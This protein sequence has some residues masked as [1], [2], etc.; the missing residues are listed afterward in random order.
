MRLSEICIKNYKSIKK[1]LKIKINDSKNIVTFIGKNGS[2]KTNILRAIRESL[3]NNNYRR[4]LIDSEY[5]LIFTS[6]EI[7]K[8]S[9]LLDVDSVTNEVLVTCNNIQNK[10]EAIRKKI[11]SSALKE[12]SSKY[13]E[14]LKKEFEVYKKASNDYLKQLKKILDQY[15]SLYNLKLYENDNVQYSYELTKDTFKSMQ[16]QYSREINRLN[17]LVE[18]YGDK[19]GLTFENNYYN[20]N[21]F[22]IFKLYQ[23]PIEKEENTRISPIILKCI[24]MSKEQIEVANM[25]FKKEVKSIN[26]QLKENYEAILNSEKN[27]EYLIDKINKVFSNKY[28]EA[29]EKERQAITKCDTLITLISKQLNKKCYFIDNE[30]SLLFYNN[31]KDVYNENRRIYLN[32]ENP[33]IKAIDNFLKTHNFY[34]EGESLFTNNTIK[35]KRAKII[36]NCINSQFLK[37]QLDK[38]NK[39]DDLEY[40][41][42]I[43]NS[44]N[45]FKM[46]FYVKEKTG[47]EININDTSLGR[48]WL[49]TYQFIEKLLEPGD[50]LLIDEPAA[51]LHPE[52]QIHFKKQLKKLAKKNIY[53]FMTTHSPYMIDDDWANVYNVSYSNEGTEIK[54]FSSD[55]E[56]V[57]VIKEELGI[58]KT[59]DI[60][61]NLS[62]TILLVE[63]KNDKICIEK[64]ADLLNY[65]IEKHCIIPCNGSAIIGYCYLCIKEKIKFKALLDY[66]TLHKPENWLKNQFGY[67]E[68]LELITNN[69]NCIFTEPRNEYES[70]EAYFSEIDASECF[71]EF[72]NKKGVRSFKIDTQKLNKKNNFDLETKNNFEQLFIK[73]G[74]PKLTK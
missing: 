12:I 74:I 47:D 56:M 13:S 9:E 27:I 24:G 58:G 65:D 44:S 66:D 20:Y 35:G 18:I 68:Y 19:N 61:F 71:T 31:Q 41:V 54:G 42:K 39:H 15:S 59:S 6:E 36:E 26:E 62:K 28:D 37:T 32:N 7:Q 50:V 40:F 30:D 1:E 14:M 48:R 73:L 25:K 38:K 70:I 67:K 5:K 2:G 8:Y 64:F 72:E 51:F 3:T 57:K 11:Y 17:N 60:L 45:S 34:L 43:E 49:L 63:G 16:D 55:D 52:M 33:I 10:N 21:R 4:E 46:N 23:L 69:K 22:V 53:I 29:T